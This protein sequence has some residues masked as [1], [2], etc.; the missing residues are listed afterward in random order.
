MKFILITSFRES[1]LTGESNMKNTQ[2]IASL[3]AKLEYEIGR[4]WVWIMARE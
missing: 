3:I 2:N 4:E 1:N